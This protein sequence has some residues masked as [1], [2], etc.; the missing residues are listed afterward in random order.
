MNILFYIGLF[1]IGIIVGYYW[2][3]K[4]E[5]IPKR[6]DLKRKYYSE[7]SNQKILS[8]LIY[9]IIGG[10]LSTIL[11]SVLK[12]N[13]YE[14]DILNLIIYI[15]AM[16]YISTLVVIAGIDKDYLK[17]DKKVIAFGIVTSI[18]YMIY[19]FVIDLFSI[20][21]NIIYLAIYM[22]LL[23]TDSFL[24]RKFAKDSYIVNILMVL[25]IILVFTNLLTLL[26]TLAIA[27]IAIG[28]YALII[29]LQNRKSGNSKL[30]ISQIPVGYYIAVS[31]IIIIMMIR[32][33]G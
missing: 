33:F 5:E 11:G 29:K 14:I 21:L 27:I 20:H 3:N 31:N 32:I 30:E 12:V 16:L 9:M 10:C 6:L 22:I 15:F 19:L 4:I 18:A 24:L 2:N 1:I 26:V 28:I 17:I 23:L 8:K 25:T 13:S 7:N